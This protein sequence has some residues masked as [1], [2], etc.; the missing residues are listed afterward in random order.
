MA[1][2]FMN[3]FDVDVVQHIHDFIPIRPDVEWV[4]V[5][6]WQIIYKTKHIVTYRWDDEGGYVYF[7]RRGRPG[8]IGGTELGEGSR[9]IHT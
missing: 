8:G 5:G 2:A 1:M 6:G 7:I 3:V 4:E 9:Y